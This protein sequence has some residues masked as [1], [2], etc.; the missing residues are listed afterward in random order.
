VKYQHYKNKKTYILVDKC[1]I[2]EK[3]K[4]VPAVRYREFNGAQCDLFFVRSEQEFNKKFKR[5][6]I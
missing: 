2:Q 1:M 3:D 4:W 5:K 6:D